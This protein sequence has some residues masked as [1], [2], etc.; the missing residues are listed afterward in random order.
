LVLVLESFST[1]LINGSR[2]IEFL[3]FL[4]LLLLTRIP[5]EKAEGANRRR[6][7][8]EETSVWGAF[9]K[10]NAYLPIL[11]LAYLF[12]APVVFLSI[13]AVTSLYMVSSV[14]LRKI[15]DTPSG[16]VL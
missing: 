15:S 3:P 6:R 11:A 16:V 14:P 9:L 12:L 4:S 13:S 2:M 8:R 10:G 5:T 7:S 1:D